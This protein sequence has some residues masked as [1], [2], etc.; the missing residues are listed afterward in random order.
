[1]KQLDEV[2]ATAIVEAYHA[3]W[4]KQ[5]VAGMLAWCHK[6]VTL[7]LNAGAP[8]GGPLRLYGRA[9][10]EVFLSPIVE[11]AISMTV[12]ISCNFRNGVARTQ[13]EAFIQHRK[14]GNVLT[15]TYR[16][17]VLFDGFKIL[18]LEEFHDAAKMKAFWDM[19]RSEEARFQHSA[20]KSHGD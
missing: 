13:I 16:Q 18:A 1:M 3:A 11:V 10:L 15:G 6:D 5:D 17:V 14:T 2:M 7:F 8:H 20:S 9:E 4:S 12:P 19:V